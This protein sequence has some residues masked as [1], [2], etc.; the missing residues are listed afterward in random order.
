MTHA[1]WNHAPALAELRRQF[2]GTC[3]G[4]AERMKPSEWAERYRRMPLSSAQRGGRFTFDAAPWQREILDA[5]EDP[6]TSA[7]VLMMAAQIGG[8]TET[9]LNILGYTIDVDPCPMLWVEPNEKPLGEAFSKERLAAMLKDTPRLRGKVA[10]ARARDS[11]ST[12]MFK[13]FPGGDLA[14]V[15]ATAP[16]GLAGRPR[17]KLFFNE[18]DRFPFSAGTEGDPMALAKMRTG[19]F[20]DAVEFKNSTPTI[21]G[22]SRI[23][24]EFD[25]SD[26]RHWFCPCPV[27]NHWQALEWEQFDFGKLG[28]GGTI[29]DPRLI[30]S[31]CGCALDDAQRQ[32]M[33]RAGEWRATA[34]FHGIRG[35]RLPGWYC[36]FK[37]QRRFKNR[38]AQ[39]VREFLD[40]QEGGNETLRV[41]WNTVKAAT[42]EN[43]A[44]KPP[45]AKTLME[46]REAYLSRDERGAVRLP[47]QVLVLVGGV[48]KQADRLELTVCGFG[49]G[50]EMWGVENIIIA[51][52]PE[53]PETWD[54]LDDA[55]Q[56][57]YLHP[58]GARLRVA[59]CLIDRGY[60][61]KGTDDFTRPRNGRRIYSCFG[62]N[63]PG[64]AIVGSPTRQG[65]KRTVAFRLGVD[66]AKGHIFSRLKLQRHGPRYMHFPEGRFGFDLEY[67]EQ[68]VSEHEEVTW[69]GGKVS[70][71]WVKTRAR[72]EAL[73]KMVYAF[74]AL[75]VLRPNFDAIAKNLAATVPPKE[76]ALAQGPTAGAQPAGPEAGARPAG[77]R[78]AGAQSSGPVTGARPLVRRTEPLRKPGMRR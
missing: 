60:K 27:C 11:G 4:A 78:P 40:A 51:G 44:E 21:K 59:A 2:F 9:F 24:R 41:W 31:G 45:E 70:R 37:P 69:Q 48:D 10:D 61:G 26:K 57:E 14:I 6:N 15:G 12:V 29:E 18:V 36:L 16:S 28:G 76:Y 50:E 74:A 52:D 38:M 17:R 58:S 22:Q 1:L 75:E 71:K 77:A 54:R 34:S 25:K 53:L 3:F 47:E 35:Y 63:T 39:M 64:Q 32:A 72:N 65:P 46:R 62:S 42:W 67:F 20:E 66:T 33:V 23:E 19:T 5:S 68:L 49:F 56:R 30:C 13:S 43:P 7:V 73:D 8:K 55:L